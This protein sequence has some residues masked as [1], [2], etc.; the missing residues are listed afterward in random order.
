MGRHDPQNLV[1][2]CRAHHTTGNDKAPHSTNA[3]AGDRFAQ[4][5][6][7]LMPKRDTA[8]K[9]IELQQNHRGGRKMNI[10]EIE[11]DHDFWA[12]VVENRRDYEFVCEAAGVE[13]WATLGVQQ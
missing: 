9:A 11:K 7:G 12:T 8:A 2:V 10:D 5:L 1:P 6:R 13:A 3:R 4:W